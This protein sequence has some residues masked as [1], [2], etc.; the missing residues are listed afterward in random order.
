MSILTHSRADSLPL[1]AAMVLDE[2]TVTEM[3]RRHLG[4]P[5]GE[6]ATAWLVAYDG[7]LTEGRGEVIA[8][9]QAAVAWDAANDG[10]MANPLA[11]CAMHGAYRPDRVGGIT[12]AGRAW[13]AAY[14]VAR[15]LGFA[16]CV[17]QAQAFA[18][19]DRAREEQP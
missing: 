7:A 9:E 1:R 10:G 12:P 19:A 2:A 11:K 4:N 8:R 6:A 14:Q 18:A 13:L 16:E 3:A 17:A 15:S 5:I